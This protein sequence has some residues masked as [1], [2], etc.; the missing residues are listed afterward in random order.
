MHLK[1]NVALL[2][3][4][5]LGFMI[6]ST[7]ACACLVPSTRSDRSGKGNEPIMMSG[8]CVQPGLFGL[9][10]TDTQLRIA[11]GTMEL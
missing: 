8:L 3:T 4:P 9:Q 2:Q 6:Y 7:A 11:S 5:D 1:E 10:M